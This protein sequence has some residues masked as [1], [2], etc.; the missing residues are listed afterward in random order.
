MLVVFMVPSTID[1]SINYDTLLGIIYPD[2]S[3]QTCAT[4]NRIIDNV[5]QFIGSCSLMAERRS[6][7]P[8]K[9][10]RFSPT[11]FELNSGGIQS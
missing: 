4:I 9:R 5:Q 1:N 10:V 8:K 6:V 7:V 2:N 11:A 3:G